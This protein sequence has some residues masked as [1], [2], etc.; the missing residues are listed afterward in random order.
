MSQSESAL[1]NAPLSGVSR[2]FDEIFLEHP[3]EAG[4]EYGA[5]L[6][7]TFRVAGYLAATSVCLVIHGLIPRFHQTTTSCRIAALNNLFKLRA[8]QYERRR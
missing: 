2:V 3:R 7:F 1:A 4:E 5:H 6:I 8:R